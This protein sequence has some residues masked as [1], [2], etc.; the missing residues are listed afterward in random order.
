[1][2]TEKCIEYF[3]FFGFLTDVVRRLFGFFGKITVLVLEF[4]V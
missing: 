2:K 3:S 1:M 4:V